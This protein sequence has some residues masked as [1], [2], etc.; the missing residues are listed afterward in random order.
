[1]DSVCTLASQYTLTT[2]LSHVTETVAVTTGPSYL[3]RLVFLHLGR[4][5]ALKRILRR[6]PVPHDATPSCGEAGRKWLSTAWLAASAEIALQENPQAVSAGTLIST[7]G[8]IGSG[9]TCP[10]CKEILRERIATMLQ[11]WVV[12]KRT[13]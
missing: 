3:R 5:E 1:M 4:T 13:I 12:V 6:Q 2:P 10:H 11:E 8:P 9:T 7:F